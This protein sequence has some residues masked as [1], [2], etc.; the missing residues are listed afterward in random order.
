MIRNLRKAKHDIQARVDFANEVHEAAHPEGKQAY[1]KIAGRGWTFYVD[2][3]EVRIGRPSEERQTGSQSTTAADAS[4]LDNSLVHI[5]LGPS[6]LVSRHHAEIRYDAKTGQ[7][8]I[9]VNGR[10]GVKLDEALLA[11]GETGILHSGCV[12]DVA[13][14]QMMFVTPSVTPSIHPII[15]AQARQQR[16]ENEDD[17]DPELDRLQPPPLPQR[18]PNNTAARSAAQTRPPSSQTQVFT[19]PHQKRHAPTSSLSGAINAH[20]D[21]ADIP[22]QADYGN[23]KASPSYARGLMLETTEDIDYS[24]DSAKD[25]KPPYSYAQLIGM[26]ILSSPE[27]KLTLSKIYDWIRERY[28]FYKLSGG[29]WQVCDACHLS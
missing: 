18:T 29:G 17:D 16:E 28:A 25:L 4:D 3:L 7:W 19:Q 6:K 1:A 14:T 2:Q 8:H 5:D 11:R 10:N 23:A 9:I 22:S 26:A 27:E 15:L 24:Q 20:D 21:G 13:G 12:I